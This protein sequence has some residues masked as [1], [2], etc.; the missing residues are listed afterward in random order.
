MWVDA[1]AP[2]TRLC[3]SDAQPGAT[4]D[5]LRPEALTQFA[6]PTFIQ[7]YSDYTLENMRN[8]WLIL[9]KG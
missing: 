7:I 8:P 9:V 2:N 4:G 3:S 1:W 6:F 5:T